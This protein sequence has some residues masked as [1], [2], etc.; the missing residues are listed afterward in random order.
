MAMVTPLP[1]G[2][3]QVFPAGAFVTGYVE[4]VRGFDA[5]GSVPVQKKDKATGLP[6]W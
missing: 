2:F 1:V 6:M 4:P 3:D 5:K